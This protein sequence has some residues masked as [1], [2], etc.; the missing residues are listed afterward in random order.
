MNQTKKEVIGILEDLC[1]SKNEDVK[2]TLATDLALD[3]LRMVTL[4]LMLEDVLEIE[5]KESD[6]NP[7]RLL[8]VSDVIA[9][10]EKYTEQQEGL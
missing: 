7:F 2:L 10:A 5:L 6:M 4:L 8:T 9:L 3:S 1:G